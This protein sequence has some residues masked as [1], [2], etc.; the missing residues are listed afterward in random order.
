M[1][2]IDV[3]YL[4]QVFV[5]QDQ[6]A[7]KVTRKKVF[8]KQSTYNNWQNSGHKSGQK[9]QT[10]WT[11]VNCRR[12]GSTKVHCGFVCVVSINVQDCFVHNCIAT[13]S[14]VVV[15]CSFVPAIVSCSVLCV[16]LFAWAAPLLSKQAI[17]L[18]NM[19]LIFS[20]SFALGQKIICRRETVER[21]EEVGYSAQ[22]ILYM[23][24]IVHVTYNTCYIYYMLNILHFTY[25]ILHIIHT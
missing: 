3:E 2:C 22:Y 18:Q 4:T 15:L 13:V 25:T 9:S 14:T 17:G 12:W 7:K 11:I 16:V 19:A 24:L 20:T 21:V 1:L 10:Y 23:W 5:A 8:W 6:S